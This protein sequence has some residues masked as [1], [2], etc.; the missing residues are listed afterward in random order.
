MGSIY[1]CGSYDHGIIRKHPCTLYNILGDK[2]WDLFTL[3]DPMMV[4]A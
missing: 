3:V 1:T 4:E 2:Q